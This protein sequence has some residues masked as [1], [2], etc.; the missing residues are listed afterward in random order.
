M[1]GTLLPHEPAGRAGASAGAGGTA[2]APDS[3][4]DSGPDTGRERVGLRI[5]GLGKRFRH[6]EAVTDL[7]LDVREGEVFGLLGPNGAGKT[8]T[9]AMLATLV[10]PTS[11]DAEIFGHRISEDVATVRHSI[12]IA[13]QAISLY[14]RLTGEEN[15]LF[16]GR[17]QGVERTRLR[18]RARALLEQAGLSAR[19]DDLVETYSGGMQRRLNLVCSVVHDPRV[20]LLDE[21]AVGVDPQSR[22]NLFGLVRDI[23]A[24]GATVVYTTHYMEEAERLCDRIAILDQGRLVALGTLDEL[25]ARVGT[26]EV[27]E[28]HG[29]LDPSRLEALPG[30]RSVERENGVTRVYVESAARALA[31]IGAVLASEGSA[32]EGVRVYAINLERVFMHLTGHRLRD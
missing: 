2:T 15:L 24:A 4:G 17:L 14:P 30:V 6:V 26:G 28:I 8:T 18:D 23:A 11:G 25:L 21:P 3:R 19:K 9:L 20:V 32:V 27:I 13:P 5:R 10:P 29:G 1:G 12:G 7:S 22:E 31:P 16:F